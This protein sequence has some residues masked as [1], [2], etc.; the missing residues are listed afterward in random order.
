MNENIFLATKNF[1]FTDNDMKAECKIQEMIKEART[2]MP[3]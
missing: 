1:S 3:N 2:F